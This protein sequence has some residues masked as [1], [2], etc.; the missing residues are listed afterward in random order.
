MGYPL[1]MNQ[2]TLKK[3]LKQATDK[4]YW[5]GIGLGIVL[6]LLA[7]LAIGYHMGS[8]QTIVIPLEQGTEI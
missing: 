2:L 3:H 7:G 5:L 6:G 1:P 8:P 4:A